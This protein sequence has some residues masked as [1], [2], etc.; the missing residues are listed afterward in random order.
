MNSK[1]FLVLFASVAIMK[2]VDCTLDPVV[3]NGLAVNLPLISATAGTLSLPLAVLGV[4]KLAAALKLSGVTLATLKGGE[5]ETYEEPHSGYGRFRARG[6]PRNGYKQ[7]AGRGKRSADDS[8]AVFSLVSSMDMYSCGKALVCA[9]EAKDSQ[10][11]GQDEQ[12][13]MALFA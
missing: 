2:I 1:Q 6:Y 5:E 10:S 3:V 7:R 12:I 9:L 8:E 13:I 11:L 4:L